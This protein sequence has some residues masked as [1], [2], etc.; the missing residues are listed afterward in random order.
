MGW[1]ISR[2]FWALENTSCI[3]STL[4]MI[5]HCVAMHTHTAH[6]RVHSKSSYSKRI[7][8]CLVM[9]LWYGEIRIHFCFWCFLILILWLV[10]VDEANSETLIINNEYW[11]DYIICLEQHICMCIRIACIMLVEIYVLC[12]VILWMQTNYILK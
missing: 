3:L 10:G 8:V 6:H 5:M 11:C 2:Y 9:C 12:A 4:V 7:Y 1:I